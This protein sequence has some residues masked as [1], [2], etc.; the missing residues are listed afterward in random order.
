MDGT[1]TERQVFSAQ[2]AARL[3]RLTGDLAPAV[4][5]LAARPGKQ[6]RSVLLHACTRGAPAPLRLLVRLGALIELLHLASLVHDDIVDRA[7]S[8]RGGPAAQLSLGEERAALAGL[9]CFAVAGKEAADLGGDLPVLVGRTAAELAYGELLDVER[10]FDTT[11][12]LPD[13]LDLVRRKTGVLFRLACVLGAAAAGADSPHVDA[14]G[15][16]GLD[17]G[18]AF[19]ILDD[20][21]DFGASAAGKPTGTDHALGLFGAPT[22]YALGRDPSGQLAAVLLAPSFTT[23]D[24]PAV[25][26]LVRERGGLS[27]AKSL[28]RHQYDQALSHLDIVDHATRTALINATARAGYAR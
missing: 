28:A 7:D 19:Q 5:A 18:V 25:R 2:V 14:L 26:D 22:L 11:L 24:M 23:A 1:D 15:R 17:F 4:R 9:S 16:F 20:T 12:S 27:A 8:R 3:R 6:L 10:A 13:Y 21:L